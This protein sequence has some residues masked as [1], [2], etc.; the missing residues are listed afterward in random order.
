LKLRVYLAS[1]QKFDEAIEFGFPSL[2]NGNKENIRPQT[3]YHP[4]KRESQDKDQQDSGR[5]FL[6]DDTVSL[7]LEL[8]SFHT[9]T[10]TTTTTNNSPKDKDGK[11]EKATITSADRRPQPLQ[12]LSATSWNPPAGARHH[13][14][15]T[16]KMTLT[17]PDLRTADDP[18]ERDD[19]PLR[20]AELPPADENNTSIWAEFPVQQGMMK[21]MWRKI[22]RRK[23]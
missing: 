11:S 1:P 12:P 18:Y 22:R 10:T 16:L 17:R 23:D 8:S 3:D 13:R 19:D 7:D 20:L 6:D 14:E 15:M 9:T 21:K 2:D 5:T 4:S